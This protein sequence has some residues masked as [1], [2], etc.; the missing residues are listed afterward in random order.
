[1]ASSR[2]STVSELDTHYIFFF[3]WCYAG[4]ACEAC[5]TSYMKRFAQHLDTDSILN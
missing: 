2:P 5:I 1:M 4:S 3:P